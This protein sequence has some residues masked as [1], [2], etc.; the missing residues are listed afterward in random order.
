MDLEGS[1]TNS[2]GSGKVVFNPFSVDTRKFE[3]KFQDETLELTLS[4]PRPG[5]KFS[6]KVDLGSIDTLLKLSFQN[7]KR[8]D[9][10]IHYANLIFVLFSF[11]QFNK[12]IGFEEVMV[13]TRNASKLYNKVGTLHIRGHEF[14]SNGKNKHDVVRLFDLTDDRFDALIRFIS[15]DDYCDLFI[16]ANKKE[17]HEVDANKYLTCCSCFEY[18]FESTHNA[19]SDMDADFKYVLERLNEELSRIK[20]ELKDKSGEKNKREYVKRFENALKRESYTLAEKFRMAIGE[21]SDIISDFASLVKE[22][23]PISKKQEKDLAQEFAKKRNEFAHGHFTL[24]ENVHLVGF[25]I[26]RALI[27]VMILKK[28]GVD[29]GKVKEIIDRMSF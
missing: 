2:D 5:I 4:I 10:L 6:D 13:H 24:F 15:K 1:K 28:I 3:T 8:P 9:E 21:Y 17:L 11:L 7:P 16:P 20:E 23:N 26:A 25:T 27:Y 18:L 29:D 22:C 19:K 12:D 14:I